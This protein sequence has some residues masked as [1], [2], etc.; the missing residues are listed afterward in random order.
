MPTSLDSFSTSPVLVNKNPKASLWAQ[1]E[2]GTF[3]PMLKTYTSLAEGIYT[4]KR[5]I[6][7]ITLTKL[8]VQ[9][10]NNILTLSNDVVQNITK[11]LKTFSKNKEVF[12]ANELALHKHF[13]I[14]GKKSY[15]KTTSL[16]KLIDNHIKNKGIAL[17][18]SDPLTTQEAL[19]LLKTIEPQV[20]IIVFIDNFDQY[21]ELYQEN[22]ILQL[23]ADKNN[24]T[25]I[26]SAEKNY[27]GFISVQ[28][29]KD[30]SSKDKE[31]YL[32][33]RFPSTDT[34]TFTSL[35]SELSG[36]KLNFRDLELIGTLLVGHDIAVKDIVKYYQDLSNNVDN[37]NTAILEQPKAKKIVKQLFL[38]S[39]GNLKTIIEEEVDD[40]VIFQ[41]EKI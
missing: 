3:Y 22:S 16:Y 20:N 9:N 28:E 39:E 23:L 5:S 15:G 37:I 24:I 8:N 41:E 34:S 19:L 14:K 21:V 30:L 40:V 27:K 18:P 38:D 33:C 17:L 1:D 26:V 36:L 7:G 4:P 11:E 6:T 32:K 29:I 25:T 2:T 12:L 35:L 31:T 10:N 13:L